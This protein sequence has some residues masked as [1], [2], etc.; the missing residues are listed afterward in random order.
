MCMP[1]IN[2][3]YKLISIFGF[4]FI[5]GHTSLAVAYP[6]CVCSIGAHK[7]KQGSCMPTGGENQNACYFVHVATVECGHC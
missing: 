2:K 6:S 7:G 5:M 4:L 1:T 3:C